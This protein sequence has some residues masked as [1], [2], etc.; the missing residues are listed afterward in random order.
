[1]IRLTHILPPGLQPEMATVSLTIDQ[2]VRSRLRIQLDDGREAGLFLGRGCL[3][4]GGDLIGNHEGMV[5]RVISAPE[6]VSTVWSDDLTLL[7]RAAYHLG[8]RHVPLQ[9]ENGW[10]RYAHDHV[11]DAMLAGM[12]LHVDVNDTVFEPEAGAYQQMSRGH[13]HAI[14]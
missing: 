12:G 6:R 5:V 2:R 3:L 13:S 7:A 11:L 1:M 4:R 10:L 9:I 8:N 14:S